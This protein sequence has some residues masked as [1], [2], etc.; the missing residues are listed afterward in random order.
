VSRFATAAKLAVASPR[1]FVRAV[2]Y[3]N[4]PPRLSNLNRLID[5]HKPS[6]IVEIGVWRGDTARR[7]IV[8]AARH[9]AAVR[10]WG[11][12]LFSTGMTT[13]IMER[14]ASLMPLTLEEVELRL[15][16]L[17][18]EVT[19]VSGD[20]S[21]TLPATDLPPIE[22]AFIDGGHS[23]ET[24]ASDWH[25]LRPRMAPGSIAVFDDYTNGLAVEHEGYGIR[26]L[27]EEL[28]RDYDI[29]LPGPTDTFERPYGALRTRLA[30]LHIPQL[31][32]GRRQLT[33]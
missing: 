7:M 32:G 33:V 23:Y 10:Y 25:N 31:S 22:L 27:V 26:A 9:H 8:A 16:G 11:F 30:V 5:T 4:G 13:E 21:V 12:D 20:S 14:E 24:V 15:R 29:E 17:G 6:T 19:L 1:R 2:Q 3:R 18:A 28:R